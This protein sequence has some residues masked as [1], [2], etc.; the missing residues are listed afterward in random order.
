MD[1]WVI[2]NLTGG[3]VHATDFSNASRTL[4][5]GLGKLEWDRNLM[6]IFEIPVQMMPEIMPSDS[7]FGYTEGDAFIP[8]GIPVSGVMGDSHAALFGQNCFSIGMT[9]ATNGTGS[10]VMM[11]IGEKPVYS[12][13]GIVTSVGWVTSGKRCMSL[14]GM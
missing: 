4:L 8:K 2:W 10:S 12:E 11:N 13:S 9:K 5:M 14:K 6:D 3:K 7:I 1:S